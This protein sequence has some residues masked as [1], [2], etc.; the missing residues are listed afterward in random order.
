MTRNLLRLL[1]VPVLILA[2]VAQCAAQNGAQVAPDRRLPEILAYIDKAWGTLGRSMD[3]CKT[4]TDERKQ[5]GRALVYFP[6][7][8]EMPPIAK[9]LESK[10]GIQT[11]K[12]PQVIKAPGSFDMHL[13]SKH[14]LLFLPNPYVVPGGF[15][16]EMYGWDSYF[17]IRGLLQAGKTQLARGMVE[18]FFFEIQ[19]YGAILNANRTYFLTR[20]Q[21]PFLSSMV[22]A[23]YEQGA[24]G[25]KPDREWLER[26]YPFIVRDYEMWT[27]G[28]HLAGNTGLSRYYDYGDGPTAD[29][30]DTG[31]AYYADV[32]GALLAGE[33]ANDYFVRQHAPQPVAVPAYALE[34]CSQGAKARSCSSPVTMELTADYYKGD[35]AM[36]ESGFDISFRFGPYSGSTHHYAPVCLNSLLYKTERD[37]EKISTVLGHP[38]Q[39]RTWA[40]RA[41]HRADLMNKYLWDPQRGMFYDW[42]FEQ[43]KRSDYNYATTFYPLWSE[44]ASPEQARAVVANLKIFEQPGGL[45][46]SDRET[47]VQ[48]DYPYGWAPIQMLSIEGLQ[49]YKFD[50]VAGRLSYKFLSMVVDNFTNDGTIRE[51]YNVVTRS[52]EVRL[53]AGYR[54]N[55]IGF[56]WTNGAFLVLLHDLPPALRTKLEQGESQAAAPKM[57]R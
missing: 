20:S 29:I 30:A 41:K 21:P 12:L 56:G 42:D 55:L 36:R 44:M 14:G 35:R 6:A 52:D 2:V 9:E 39:A 51:K 27:T 17:I 57:T 43:N 53:T 31:D 8:M 3:D 33:I 23:V 1:L 26:A 15:F 13:L 34:V 25:G 54:A 18:N 5:Q 7:E 10:C 49:H 38:D 24:A 4:V 47:K 37:L 16:N 50:D 40:D 45:V 48:W 28:Q 19:H 32:I 22:L 11:A 46:M